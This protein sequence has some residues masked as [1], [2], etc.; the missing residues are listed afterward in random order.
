MNGPEQS[1]CRAVRAPRVQQ[2]SLQVVL[3]E[4]VEW[5]RENPEKSVVADA[6]VVRLLNVGELVEILPVFVK[7]LDAIVRAIGDV[8]AAIFIDRDRVRRLELT[9]T[10]AARAPHQ[11]KL[12]VLVELGH[13]RIS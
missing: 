6:D 5:S 1:W 12:A 2:M 7:H 13:A 11:E 4:L 9:V 8:D 3:Q 10:G